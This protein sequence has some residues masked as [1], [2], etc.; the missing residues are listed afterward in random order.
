MCRGHSAGAGAGAGAGAVGRAGGGRKL[1]RRASPPFGRAGEPFEPGAQMLEMIEDLRLLTGQ[2][3]DA[4]L[5]FVNVSRLV[6]R[7]QP[8]SQLGEGRMQAIREVLVVVD[9]RLRP[10]DSGEPLAEP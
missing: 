6:A 4:V 8:T 5:Q 9:D 3:A 2:L 1:V 7:L 10:G